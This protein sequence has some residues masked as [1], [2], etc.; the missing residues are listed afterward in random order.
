MRNQKRR[1]FRSVLAGGVALLI[2]LTPSVALGWGPEA[3][4]IIA[5]I[6]LR[7]LNNNAG[8][9]AKKLMHV[10]TKL[11]V[12][13]SSDFVLAST[14]ADDIKNLRTYRQEFSQLHFIENPF[15]R[16]G[17]PPTPNLVTALK[18]NVK[19]L[20]T[21]AE[22]EAEAQALRFII[23]FV[24]DIHQPLHC[25]TR[26]DNENR[27]DQGGN[28]VSILV[29]DSSGRLR[30]DRLHVYWDSGLNT[31]AGSR[32]THADRIEK[33]SPDQEA[34]LPID[35]FNFQG[36]SD[37]SFNLAKEVAYAGIPSGI[38]SD[39]KV[40]KKAASRSP[41]RVTA[42]YRARA[43]PIVNLQIARSGY[44]LAKLL[45]AIWPAR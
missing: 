10:K 35:P 22:V 42:T 25:A 37:E 5:E 1:L 45:N 20:Q 41:Y 13:N 36:W 9:R 28:R 12:P 27:G 31:L 7:R 32:F 26:L 17:P 8:P 21:G 6:A 2:L 29:A 44:R 39:S 33:A 34:N 24:G 4:R 14:W 23:H 18:D 15:P 43:V 11:W 3:H 19:I 40:D 38:G 16:P 30:T